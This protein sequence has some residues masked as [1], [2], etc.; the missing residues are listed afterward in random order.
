M[1]RV[2]KKKECELSKTERKCVEEGGE[3]TEGRAGGGA[4][5]SRG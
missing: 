1:S 3:S 5:G 2:K 4:G